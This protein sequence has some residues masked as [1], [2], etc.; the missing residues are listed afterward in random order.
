MSFSMSWTWLCCK[1]WV[2]FC[3]CSGMVQD[4]ATFGRYEKGS[5]P[6]LDGNA[7]VVDVPKTAA[8][9]PLSIDC[10]YCREHMRVTRTFLAAW[11][12]EMRSLISMRLLLTS[13]SSPQA[14]GKHLRQGSKLGGLWEGSEVNNNLSLAEA[15]MSQI[16][17][18]RSEK[19]WGR[20]FHHR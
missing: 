15:S 6:P 14:L 20:W 8:L 12:E 7:G 9:V 1:S 2:W 11:N 10:D 3:L 16:R 18:T 19:K 17:K 13:V 5:S 4:V